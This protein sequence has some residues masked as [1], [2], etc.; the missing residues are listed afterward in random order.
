M[1][2]PQDVKNSLLKSFLYFIPMND[3]SILNGRRLKGRALKV[4]GLT[5][6][7]KGTFGKIF[8]ALQH[9]IDVEVHQGKITVIENKNVLRISPEN[10]DIFWVKINSQS[11]SAISSSGP[12]Y[13]SMFHIH[14]DTYDFYI[15]IPGARAAQYLIANPHGLIINDITK[16]GTLRQRQSEYDLYDEINDVGFDHLVAGTGL[17]FLDLSETENIRSTK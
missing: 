3:L 8:T 10:I 11:Y 1:I 13:H 2:D 14:S 6:P 12:I 5:L 4:D 16:I 15:Q 9:N 7:A 17:E